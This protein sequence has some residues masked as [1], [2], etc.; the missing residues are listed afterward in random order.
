[1]IVKHFLY[2]KQVRSTCTPTIR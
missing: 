2:V 1:M